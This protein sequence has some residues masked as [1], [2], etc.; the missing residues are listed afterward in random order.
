MASR[1]FWYYFEHHNIIIPLSQPLK[2]IIK[3]REAS[4]QIGKWALEL[5]EFVIGFVNRSF[6][7]SQALANFIA[8]WTPSPQHEASSSCLDSF[9][10]W[11]MWILRCWCC[12]YCCFAIQSKYIICCQV[13]ILVRK[14]YSRIWSSIVGLEETEGNGYKKSNLEI[15]FLGHH[16]PGG[17]VK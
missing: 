8:D 13:A 15:R 1:K 11:F 3:N 14:Y 7:Q 4:G 5:N 16:R 10:W 9:L 6:I 2:D 17:Q 12:N